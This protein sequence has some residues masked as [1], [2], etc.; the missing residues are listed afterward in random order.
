MVVDVDFIFKCVVH[1]FGSYQLLVSTIHDAQISLRLRFLIQRLILL[2]NFKFIIPITLLRLEFL[3]KYHIATSSQILAPQITKFIFT[4]FANVLTHFTILTEILRFMQQM[5]I[6]L[7]VCLG[8]VSLYPMIT[9][10]TFDQLENVVQ[11]SL[12]GHT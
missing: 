3:I 12:C 6:G 5:D 11:G 4:M 8:E 10:F 9:R 1:F 7:H 2:I